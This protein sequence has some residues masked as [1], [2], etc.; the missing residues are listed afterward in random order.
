MSSRM[1]LRMTST[2]VLAMGLTGCHVHQQD[3]TQ[4]LSPAT[5]PTTGPSRLAETPPAPAPTS[6]PNAA[7]APAVATV[8]AS[9]APPQKPFIAFSNPFAPE[10]AKPSVLLLAHARS[11]SPVPLSLYPKQPVHALSEFGLEFHMS[12]DDVVARFGQPA[13]LANYGYEWVV[14]RLDDNRE[15]WLHFTEP[16]HAFLLAADVVGA[17]EDGYTR[18][19]IFTARVR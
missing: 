8:A 15:L 7:P 10:P 17:A 12:A 11:D 6:P 2:M 19:R 5:E 9:S 13:Q 4:P 3:A 1:F 14:Y 16:N 18:N